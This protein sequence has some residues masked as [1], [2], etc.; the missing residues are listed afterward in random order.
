LQLNSIKIMDSKSR[1]H[2]E[3]L[4]YALFINVTLVEQA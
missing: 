2:Q 1:S 3:Y 4:K